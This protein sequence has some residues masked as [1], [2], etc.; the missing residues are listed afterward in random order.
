M[1]MVSKLLQYRGQL[2]NPDRWFIR[3]LGGLDT[4]TGVLVDQESALSSTS[5]LAILKRIS[6]D[7]ASVPLKLIQE[8]GDRQKRAARDHNVWKVLNVRANPEQTAMDFREMV[9]SFMLS[10][11]NGYAEIVRDQSAEIRE[12]WPITPHRVT[13]KRTETGT[14]FY[15]VRNTDGT[16]RAVP[17]ENML[18]LRS[19]TRDGIMGLDVIEQMREAIG[20]NLALEEYSARFFGQGTAASGFLKYPGHLKDEDRDRLNSDWVAKNSGLRSMHR[21]LILE[22]GMDWVQN[23]VSPEA[24]QMIESRKFTVSEI[25][26]IWQIPP[27]L[28]GDLERATFSN[29]EQQFL[30]YLILTLRHHYV[31]WEQVGNWRLLLPS[32]RDAGFF[33][34]HNTA[35]LLSATL[36]E[37]LESYAIAIANGIFSP[38]DA[39]DSEDLNAYPGGDVYVLPLNFAPISEAGELPESTDEP[40]EPRGG[41]RTL[42]S[43]NVRA[44]RSVD[45]RRRLRGVH[46]E[47][48]AK[49]AARALEIEIKKIRALIREELG[50]RGLQELSTKIAEFYRFFEGDLTRMMEPVFF[51]YATEIYRAAADEVGA[52]SEPP[53][54]LS[55]FVQAYAANFSRRYVKANL[56]QLQQ[57]VRDNATDEDLAAI[58]DER[59]VE[60]TETRADKVGARETI[61][62]E[63][64][65][66]KFTYL[67]A[68]VLAMRWVAIGKSCPLCEKLDGR[69]VGIQSAFLAKGDVLDPEGVAPLHAQQTFTHPPIHP[70]CDCIIVAA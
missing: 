10:A 9:T 48:I 57:T 1:S 27:H 11:G 56:G 5:V 23:S 14:L 2:Q 53:A 28:V 70:G 60:W 41:T 46:Q 4:A 37:R 45:L 69:T 44:R 63:G 24:A 52:P 30:E 25:S 16:D 33:L 22:E 35:A 64:A 59:L 29:V 31:R 18:H 19:F 7:V 34:K 42:P 36:K 65:V 39:R 38:N 54:N 66:S 43:L 15:L 32:E 49:T 40:P 8:T 17:A 55:P 67:A 12:L 6:G 51:A 13:L 3:N 62:A 58:I 68:G 20:L 61:E 26:R 50:T 21:T 47:Q